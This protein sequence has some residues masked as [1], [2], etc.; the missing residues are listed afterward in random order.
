MHLSRT[1]WA[2]A[3]AVAVTVPLA[4]SAQSVPAAPQ[5]PGQ[6]HRHH[7]GNRFMH[8]LHSLDLSAAQKQQI[9]GFIKDARTAN[10]NAEPAMHKANAEKLHAQIQG[11]LTPDQRTQLQTELQRERTAIPAR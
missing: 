7:R 1:L 4:A 11:V 10:H 8:A 9:A 5:P 6:H 3:L 2:A